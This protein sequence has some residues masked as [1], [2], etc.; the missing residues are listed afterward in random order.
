MLADAPSQ[1]RAALQQELVPELRRRGFSGSFPN[2]RRIDLPAFLG[3][4]Q[5]WEMAPT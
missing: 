1:M 2:F 5:C 4:L 3:P